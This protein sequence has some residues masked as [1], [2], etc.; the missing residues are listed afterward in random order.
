VWKTTPLEWARVSEGRYML[1]TSSTISP[2]QLLAMTQ[3]LI[4]HQSLYCAAKLGVADLLKDGPQTCSDLARTLKVNESALY[5]LL[6]SFS[7]NE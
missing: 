5:R 7:A 4:I 2:M 1:Q 6:L 3:G